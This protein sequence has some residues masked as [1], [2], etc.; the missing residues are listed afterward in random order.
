MDLQRFK[1]LLLWGRDRFSEDPIRILRTMP[2]LLGLVS[3]HT[4]KEQKIPKLQIQQLHLALSR[5]KQSSRSSPLTI[6]HDGLQLLTTPR[7]PSRHSQSFSSFMLW[8]SFSPYYTLTDL[9]ELSTFTSLLVFGLS[10]FILRG[11]RPEFTS[12]V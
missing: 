8:S 4:V 6:R 11:S 3:I 9:T 10:A 12:L 7:L 2:V 1:F 5:M